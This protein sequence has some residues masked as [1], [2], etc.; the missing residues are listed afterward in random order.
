MKWSQELDQTDNLFVTFEIK[1]T[2]TYRLS[3]YIIVRQTVN[4]TGGWMNKLAT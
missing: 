1:I 4:K 3:A 2:N